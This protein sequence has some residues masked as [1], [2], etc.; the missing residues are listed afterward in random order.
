MSHQIHL[1]FGS[2]EPNMAPASPE[3]RVTNANVEDFKSCHRPAEIESEFAGYIP[4]SRQ[5]EQVILCKTLSK[6][7]VMKNEYKKENLRPRTV[8]R[9]LA[10]RFKFLW[11]CQK[12]SVVQT[13]ATNCL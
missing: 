11:W 3:K 13:I 12:R 8:E 9:H 4:E 7:K 6:E 5:N 10:A 2:R 1:P